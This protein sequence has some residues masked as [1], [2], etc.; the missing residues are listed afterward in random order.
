MVSRGGVEELKTPGVEE[1]ITSGVEEIIT[2]G[3][4]MNFRIGIGGESRAVKKAANNVA[5]FLFWI[6]IS[7]TVKVSGFMSSLKLIDSKYLPV[8]SP[9]KAGIVTVGRL[10]SI[11][12]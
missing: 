3:G 6:V 12:T 10:V 1:I 8:A 9:V 2:S 4:C 11:D 7:L 5:A